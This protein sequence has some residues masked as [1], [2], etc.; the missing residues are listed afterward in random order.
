MRL[1]PQLQEPK[2]PFPLAKAVS[3]AGLLAVLLAMVAA[4]LLAAEVHQ[5]EATY[6]A[7]HPASWLR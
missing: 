2:H 5:K 1:V 3:Q 7:Q 6:D 4:M